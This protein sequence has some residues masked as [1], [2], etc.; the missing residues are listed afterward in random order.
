MPNQVQFSG[1]TN[2]LNFAFDISSYPWAGIFRVDENFQI[3]ADMSFRL[4][5]SMRMLFRVP[6]AAFALAPFA[7]LSCTSPAEHS[8][9]LDPESPAY[10]T[11]GTLSG[12]VTTFYQPYQS[13]A[14]AHVELQPPGLIV[15]SNDEGF[16]YF[17]ELAPGAY[18]MTATA[19]GY[20]ART[21][22]VEVL[23]RQSRAITF[24][25]DALPEVVGTSTLSMRVSTR[26]S[27]TP[28][29]FWEVNAEIADGDGPNDIKRVRVEIPV[30]AFGDT[31][32]RASISGNWHRIFTAEELAGIN[33][34]N[35]V[36]KPVQIV[37]EDLPGERAVSRE[38]YLARIIT[39]EA[40]PIT[41][42]N[43]EIILARSPLLRWLL[44]AIPFEHTLRVEVFRLDAGFPILILTVPNLQA[45]ST[46][47]PYPGSLTTGSYF[48]T[49]RIVDSY[50][51]SS[52]SEEALFQVR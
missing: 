6:F 31:L 12:F 29:L 23:A 4:A 36:G 37:A 28:R 33:L 17:G 44:P 14:G 19:G 51:N 38:F 18:A 49:V 50:G 2:G 16:Y 30:L 45:G 39:E 15:P 35:L 13:V 42:A 11:H 41:P 1:V 48:W 20:A 27:E 32:A 22:N 3:V 10:A 40:Q 9:P 21:M 26:E 47:L 52:R 46:S 43:G 5:Q 24:R 25:L 8:N 7:M 34:H